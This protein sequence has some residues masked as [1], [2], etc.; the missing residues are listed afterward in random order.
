M[1]KGASGEHDA[2]LVAF[3]SRVRVLREQQ[4][5][6]QEQLA[7]EA[8]L[9]RTVVGFIERGDREVGITKVWALADALGVSAADL[10]V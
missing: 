1:V 4:G 3:G 5:L 10:F 2:H 7:H 8:R 9:H 6:S